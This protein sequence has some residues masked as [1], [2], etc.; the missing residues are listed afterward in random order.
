MM[1]A[2]A[3]AALPQ[4]QYVPIQWIGA[5]STTYQFQLD[6]V[7]TIYRPIPGVYIFCRQRRSPHSDVANG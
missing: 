7:G 4:P 5:S 2:L 3:P 6:K 1:S